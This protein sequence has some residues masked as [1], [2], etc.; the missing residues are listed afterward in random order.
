MKRGAIVWALL[1]SS[2]SMRV[3]LLLTALA[4]ALLA[5][6]WAMRIVQPHTPVFSRSMVRNPH[7]VEP[8]DSSKQPD[9][10][11]VSWEL[12]G[13]HEY[14]WSA[15]D[16]SFVYN[17]S[18]IWQ[19]SR[20]DLDYPDGVQ[21]Q[22][23]VADWES[24]IA[25][26]GGRELR[27]LGAAI[28]LE[29][30]ARYILGPNLGPIW[31]SERVWLEDRLTSQGLELS[32]PKLKPNRCAAIRLWILRTPDIWNEKDFALVRLRDRDTG[33]PVYER[34]SQIL[35][36]LGYVDM[37]RVAEQEIAEIEINPVAPP[38]GES[39]L[40][41]HLHDVDVAIR[42]SKLD[43]LLGYT[44]TYQNLAA[45]PLPPRTLNSDEEMMD[46]LSAVLQ[47]EAPGI[48]P[49][50]LDDL[51]EEDWPIEAARFPLDTSG[52]TAG[53]LLNAWRARKPD[54]AV[55]WSRI[56]SSPVATIS[57]IAP[58]VLWERYP[59][60]YTNFLSFLM[61]PWKIIRILLIGYVLL[62]LWSLLQAMRLRDHLQRCGYTRI[63]LT[64]AEWLY[65]LLGRRAWRIPAYDELGAV[66]DVNP[67]DAKSIARVMRK[68]QRED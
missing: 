26:P 54:H 4:F 1:T 36:Y 20:W 6:P 25:L 52:M 68:A 49:S 60:R 40:W 48:G 30:G 55:V 43:G 11:I 64:Q 13:K 58:Q 34:K 37:S 51:P 21:D 28:A 50:F 19:S 32:V 16:P 9:R 2:N 29:G 59:T 62:W 47:G 41:V 22:V 42:A 35:S 24:P 46:L 33:W 56:R 67:D 17:R 12:A 53:D 18:G 31:D 15:S 7:F 14:R 27:I 5:T 63:G 3:A 45:V 8:Y 65:L 39:L 61:S 10:L 23:L 66:P 38:T 44:K 57:L